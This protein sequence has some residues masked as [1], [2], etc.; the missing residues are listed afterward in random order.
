MSKEVINELLG[1]ENLKIIQ[2]PDMF[3]FSLDST[4]LADF[5]MPREKTKRILDLGT[6]NAPV[7]LFLSLKTKAHITGI[8]IQKAVF[9]LAKRSVALNGLENQITILNEDI[10]G[11]H[12]LFEN[13][14]FDMVTCN[15]PFFKYKETSNTNVNEFKTIARHE[16]KVTLEEI[17]FEVKR[18]LKTR[19]SFCMVHR[20]ARLVEIISLLEKYDFSIKRMR[21]VY[22]KKGK[23]SNMVLI[24][25]VNNTKAE[26][27]LLEPLYVHENNGY[28]EEIS[29][30]FN[31]GKEVKR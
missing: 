30:I 18:V 4:L 24:D 9:D 13:S 7:P 22:P 23:E 16:I 1:Y 11:I 28:T 20:T 21:F 3:H 5:A 12:Q 31:Y 6:G 10:K 19:G 2:R 14:T 15:P 29:R 25:A 8:E 17:I 26:L 27:K